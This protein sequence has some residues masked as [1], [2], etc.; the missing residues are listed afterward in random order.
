[1]V[2]FN[3]SNSFDNATL[4]N[5][6]ISLGGAQ[7]NRI[8]G[9]RVITVGTTPSAENILGGLSVYVSLTATGNYTLTWDGDFERTPA[10]FVKTD[11]T[12]T[13]AVPYSVTTSGCKVKVRTWGG[14]SFA[15]GNGT[16]WLYAVAR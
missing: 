6:V 2:G 13:Q 1:M 14:A 15:L 12:S 3:D 16:F 11:T 5:F 4:D 8:I 10:L 9:A 7:G